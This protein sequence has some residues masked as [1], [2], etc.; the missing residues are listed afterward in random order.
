MRAVTLFQ[1]IRDIQLMGMVALLILVDMLL[2][3]TWNLTDPVRCSRS[4]RAIVKVRLDFK[5]RSL[6]LYEAAGCLHPPNLM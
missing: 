4:V 6:D 5:I 3:T 2:L 1:I